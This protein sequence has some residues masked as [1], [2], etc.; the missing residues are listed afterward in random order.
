M[1]PITNVPPVHFKTTTDTLDEV[2]DIVN[3][4]APTTKK[5]AIPRDALI[6][7]LADHAAMAT[8]I[9]R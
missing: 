8:I 1:K 3:R 6:A 5:V 4:S 9:E 2:W 7:L